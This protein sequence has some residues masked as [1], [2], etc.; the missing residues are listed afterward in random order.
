[1]SKYYHV[2]S[3][4]NLDSIFENGLVPECGFL[5]DMMLE[6]RRGVYLFKELAE[7][8]YAMDNWFGDNI[9]YIYDSKNLVLLEVELPDDVKIEERF[10]WEA[11]CRSVIPPECISVIDFPK[12]EKQN[13]VG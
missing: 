11:V 1:M 5:S 7:V 6:Q 4:N 9:R 3:L 10:G 8:S 12:R 13:P 2:T